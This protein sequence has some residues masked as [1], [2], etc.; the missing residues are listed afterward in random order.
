[1]TSIT[2]IREEAV[3]LK[4]MKNN[5]FQCFFYWCS[6]LCSQRTPY[7]EHC[8][9]WLQSTC[10]KGMAIKS[11]LKEKST[12]PSAASMTSGFRVFQHATLRV[13]VWCGEN[14][15]WAWIPHSPAVFQ[16][17]CFPRIGDRR[18][19]WASLL[20]DGRGNRYVSWSDLGKTAHGLWGSRTIP[21]YQGP[22]K[23]LCTSGLKHPGEKSHHILFRK[24]MWSPHFSPGHDGPN[25]IPT[26]QPTFKTCVELICI[27]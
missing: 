20:G 14:L 21:C 27:K 26:T 13:K 6:L 12:N 8:S 15:C 24:L 23:S 17:S 5:W 22:L 25:I 7:Q 4:F 10:G 3:T 2:K 1:M 9:L 19:L 16:W 18:D 11:M